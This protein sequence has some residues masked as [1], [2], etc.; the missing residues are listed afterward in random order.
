MIHVGMTPRTTDGFIVG[1]LERKHTK[2]CDL[3]EIKMEHIEKAK[4]NLEAWIVLF[5]K[6][7]LLK[8]LAGIFL[9]IGCLKNFR[10]R[11]FKA[12]I[13]GTCHKNKLD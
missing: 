3:K 13:S 4:L 5:K 11:V 1:K 7:K 8:T 6:R 10:L 12:L 2:Q 9:T